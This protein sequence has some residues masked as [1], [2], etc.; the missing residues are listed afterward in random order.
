VTRVFHSFVKYL[1]RLSLLIIADVTAAISVL[2]TADA[3]MYY[4][5]E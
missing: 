3:E 1:S 4:W 2:V 5:S